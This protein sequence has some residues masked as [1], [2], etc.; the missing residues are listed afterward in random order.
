MIYPEGKLCTSNNYLILCAVIISCASWH[1]FFNGCFIASIWL[2]SHCAG[3]LLSLKVTNDNGKDFS[4]SSMVSPYW[5]SRWSLQS[6]RYYLSSS[7]R[8]HLPFPFLLVAMSVTPEVPCT[9]NDA[10]GWCWN[11]ILLCGAGV[12]RATANESDFVAVEGAFMAQRKI[13]TPRF[14]CVLKGKKNTVV[15]IVDTM[16]LLWAGEIPL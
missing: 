7:P 16:R 2:M 11:P 13:Y 8:F 10:T 4:L 15:M 3:S 1:H 5:V 12:P 6:R 9:S 14:N